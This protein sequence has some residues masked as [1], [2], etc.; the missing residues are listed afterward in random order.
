MLR[1]ARPLQISRGDADLT[2]TDV[3]LSRMTHCSSWRPSPAS[4]CSAH[5]RGSLSYRVATSVSHSHK[6]YPLRSH[7]TSWLIMLLIILLRPRQLGGHMAH[8]NLRAVNF[9]K[10][11]QHA[12]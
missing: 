12:R 3:N 11:R 8:V 9:E 2:G 1:K 10:V 5:A 4:T 6:G 7:S